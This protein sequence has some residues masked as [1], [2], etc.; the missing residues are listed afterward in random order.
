MEKLRVIIADDERPAR[1]YLTS[2]LREF[3][4]VLLVGEAT[5]GREA[6]ELIERERPDLSFLDLEMPELDG[7][8]VV[9]LVRKDCLSLVAFVTAFDEYAVEAFELHAVDYLLK[10]VEKSRLGDTLERAHERLERVEGIA[11]QA[12]RIDNAVAEYESTRSR[13]YLER[14][15]VRRGEEIVI[16]PVRSI[17]SI[18]AEGELLHI[19]TSDNDRYSFNYRLKDLEARLNPAKFLRLSRGSLVNV[20]SISH[21]SPMPGGTYVVTLINKQQLG[22]SRQQSRILRDQ[23]LKI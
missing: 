20:E 9:R 3:D 6:V 13:G 15:P 1:S 5:T 7:I 19:T 16:L 8:S 21:V 18:V 23:L 14:L 10:P 22:V 12:T 11:E 2:L 17:V 4:D